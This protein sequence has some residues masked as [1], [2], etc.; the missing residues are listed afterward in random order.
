MN[1]IYLIISHG[2]V[3]VVGYFIGRYWG[4]PAKLLKA[5]EKDYGDIVAKVKGRI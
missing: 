1:A 3:L 2:V 5:L 4:K